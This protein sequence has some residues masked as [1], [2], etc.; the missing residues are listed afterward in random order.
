M[1]V[2]KKNAKAKFEEYLDER[3][4]RTHDGNKKGYRGHT[5]VI[6]ET[7]FTNI[8]NFKRFVEAVNRIGYVDMEHRLETM[9]TSDSYA[10][11]CRV[12]SK[13]VNYTL[14]KNFVPILERMGVIEVK[15]KSNNV[16]LG[17][18]LTPKAVE[19]D[20]SDDSDTWW[21]ICNEFVKNNFE[22]YRNENDFDFLDCLFEIIN[23][24]EITY[25]DKNHMFIILDD[26]ID[27]ERKKELIRYYLEINKSEIEKIKFKDYIDKKFKNLNN[28]KN[29]KEMKDWGNMKNQITRLMEKINLMHNFVYDSERGI[30]SIKDNKVKYK[31]RFRSGTDIRKA[32][33]IHGVEAGFDGHHIVPHENIMTATGKDRKLIENPS[34]II[35]LTKDMHNRFPNRN[36]HYI[37]LEETNE[38]IRFI[39]IID[40][41]DFIE[42]HKQDFNGNLEFIPEMVIHN[43]EIIRYLQSK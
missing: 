13:D 18:N 37:K 17:F 25:I 26:Q 27:S 10:E 35:F 14:M 40:E 2:N 22:W 42:F 15:R 36:N 31:A 11:I 21:S 9:P 24:C 4:N 33:E 16:I 32:K 8:Q 38:T 19:L 6:Q 29:K 43:K 34:N 28:D 7:F 23:D 12:V 3:L 30:V 5:L 41:K 39:S 1:I 20:Q